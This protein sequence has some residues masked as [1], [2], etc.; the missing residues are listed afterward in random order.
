MLFL[1]YE[2]NKP[3]TQVTAS[4]C[5]NNLL[6]ILP[7]AP[8]TTNLYLLC[9]TLLNTA[10]NP[11]LF[12][13]QP[14][15]PPISICSVPP[16]INT[17]LNPKYCLLELTAILAPCICLVSLYEILLKHFSFRNSNKAEENIEYWMFQL[18]HE[19]VWLFFET[20]FCRVAHP[21]SNLFY[22][23]LDHIFRGFYNPEPPI[24]ISS[25]NRCQLQAG[26]VFPFFFFFL[27]FFS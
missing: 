18:F 5:C 26:S 17:A 4:H 20:F 7:P 8:K 24:S 11:K 9:P 15:K 16:L 27:F 13:P 25:H 22:F 3:L 10:L 19:Y 12:C 6:G 21:I 14:P 23:K 2:G 1:N